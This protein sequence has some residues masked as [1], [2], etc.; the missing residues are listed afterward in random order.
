[1]MLSYLKKMLI[2]VINYSMNLFNTTDNN[3]E[4]IDYYD[5]NLNE[6]MV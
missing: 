5:I 6:Y 1:M 4:Y 3:C 2:N